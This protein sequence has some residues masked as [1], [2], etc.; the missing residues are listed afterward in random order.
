MFSNNSLL[1][2]VIR[3]YCDAAALDSNFEI[4]KTAV[5]QSSSPALVS[6]TH[7][8]CPCCP[9]TSFRSI[10]STSCSSLRTES[11]R[12]LMHVSRNDDTNGIQRNSSRIVARGVSASEKNNFSKCCKPEKL[13]CAVPLRVRKERGSRCS[14]PNTTLSES[15]SISKERAWTTNVRE[16]A[17]PHSV[18]VTQY[19]DGCTTGYRLLA[20]QDEVE[21]SADRTL[22]SSHCVFSYTSTIQGIVGNC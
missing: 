21:A 7:A 22:H 3:L 17:N 4:P 5:P 20:H 12:Q 16:L 2:T 13:Q 19:W 14:F 10:R 8:H 9:H 11:L 1:D 18:I 15:S 6:G